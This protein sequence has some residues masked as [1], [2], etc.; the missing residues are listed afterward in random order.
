MV[1]LSELVAAVSKSSDRFTPEQKADLR[2]NLD[3]RLP[4]K[5]Q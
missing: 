5:R 4:A 1:T 3:A 2:A